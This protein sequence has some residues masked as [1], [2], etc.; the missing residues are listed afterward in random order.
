MRRARLDGPV[1]TLLEARGLTLPPPLWSTGAVR[2]HRDA[3]SRAHRTWA[4]AGAHVHTAATFRAKRSDAGADGRALAAEA[5]TCC[6]EAVPTGHRVL[7]SLAPIED[8]WHP[9][10]AP[11]DGREVYREAARWLAEAGVDGLLVE[12]FANPRSAAQATE[13][14]AATGLPVW[15]A[16]TPGFEGRLLSPQALSDA[17]RR[18]RDV[19][20]RVVLVNCLRASTATPWLEALAAQG[21]PWGVYPNAGPVRDGLHG[22]DAST[23]DR[24]RQWWNPLWDDENL[25]V[26]GGC[27]GTTP[28]LT[29]ALSRLPDRD[30]NPF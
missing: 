4:E 5:V 1:G 8:C 7:G 10:D 19:G 23:E 2:T 24:W 15:T 27:C 22:D 9:E 11:E 14:A 21:Q 13:A 20:A 6:R 26:V 16:L 30:V 17:A 3:L 18:V 28:A 25:A 12:T 29:K